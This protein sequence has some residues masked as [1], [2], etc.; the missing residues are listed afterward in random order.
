MKTYPLLV[1]ALLAAF[2]M[3]PVHGQTVLYS[4]DF[5]GPDGSQ[6]ADWS[7]TATTIDLEI[8]N[9]AYVADNGTGFG[10]AYF[11]GTDNAGDPSSSWTDYTVTSSVR[12]VSTGNA[13]VIARVFSA[14]AFYTA[15]INGTGG[16][17]Y[18]DL[19]RLG[20]PGGSIQMDVA[21]GINYQSGETWTIS[22]SVVG[23]SITAQLWDASDELVAT[24]G[25]TDSTYTSGA[26]GVRGNPYTNSVTWDDFTVQAIPEPSESALT[27][28]IL[29]ATV[30]LS[31]R[32]RGK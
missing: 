2:V 3:T 26:A 10:I 32:V 21:N 4:T 13:G 9:N 28:A 16:G 17:S 18:F 5:S 29:I 27:F 1:V 7:V 6:P 22:L 31:K 20:G 15:R 12:S 25:G 14:S 8:L 19:Y 24:I 23:S 11:N 30:A